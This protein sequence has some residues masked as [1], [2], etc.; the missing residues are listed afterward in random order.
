VEWVIDI[1]S[2][3]AAVAAVLLLA[4]ALYLVRVHR[5]QRRHHELDKASERLSC[6]VSDLQNTLGVG[7]TFSDLVDRVSNETK[8]RRENEQIRQAGEDIRKAGEDI[9]KAS[10]DI[11]ESQ[12]SR[13]ERQ[14][15]VRQVQEDERQLREEERQRNGR[16]AQ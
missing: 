8:R 2:F 16:K 13:R 5:E 12:E 6:S 1:L 3:I 15:A 10:E 14:E 11:R 7:E 4:Y 9:R